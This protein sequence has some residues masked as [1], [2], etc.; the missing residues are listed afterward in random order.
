M[1]IYLN[2]GNEVFKEMTAGKGFADV[3]FI[4][5]V[6][7]APAMVIEMKHNK[8]AESAITQIRDK[9]YFDSL[10][11]YQGNL[12]F[13]GINYNE[14]EKTHTCRIEKMVK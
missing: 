12:L 4:P 2:P 3:V 10:N 7:N 14:K 5:I 6:S 1:G 8:C 13:V 11:H 9:Q